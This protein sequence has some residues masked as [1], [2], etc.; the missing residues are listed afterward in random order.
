[1]GIRCAVIGMGFWGQFM[2]EKIQNSDKYNA[3]AV[4]NRTSSIESS[5][6]LKGASFYS[7]LGEMF[8]KE[9]L[10]AVFICTIPST[11]LEITRMAAAHGVHVFCEKPL[12][13]TIDDCDAMI[14]ACVQS[15]VLLMTGF[16][17]RFAQSFST[18]KNRLGELGKPLWAMYTYPLWEVGNPDW[19]FD[20]NGTRGIVI[21]NMVHAFDAL[22]Y[23]FGDVEHV[24]AE[25]DNFIFKDHVPPDSAVISMRFKNGAIAGLGGGCTGDPRVSAEHL[26]MHFEKGIVKISGLLDR[27]YDLEI[28]MRDAEETECF[29]FEGSTGIEEEIDH[30]RACIE[31]GVSLNTTGEDGR[32]ALG[33]ALAVLSSIEKGTRTQILIDG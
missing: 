10:D 16:K 20:P 15:D 13:N 17:H 14:A 18:V 25:G 22:R 4:Y 7:D 5:L 28:L 9:K 30:F 19:K 26:L 12:A 24:Y 21:E 31:R 8:D 2:L 23:L 27:P 1:M 32:I 6:K 11:H 29:H 33:T 3:A